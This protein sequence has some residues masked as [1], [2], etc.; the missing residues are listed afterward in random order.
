MSQ[1]LNAA[2]RGAE[3]AAFPIHEVDTKANTMGQGWQ[4]IAAARA[5]ESGGDAAAM[6]EAAAKARSTL[7]TMVYVDT[8]EYLHRGGRIGGAA[9][10]VGTLL[11]L[12]P[13]ILVN[14][15]TGLVEPGARTRTRGKAIEA[16]YQSFF[17]KMKPDRPLH[18]AVM[19]ANVPDLA[20][21]IADRIRREY[22]SAELIVALTSAVLGTHIGPGAIALCGYYE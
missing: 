8:L 5:R 2:R 4:V 13:Q 21:E 17:A 3:I 15:E 12:K 10:L 18:I 11:D 6:V 22:A 16:A 9:S 1:T 7:A 20:Q 19:H 14:H